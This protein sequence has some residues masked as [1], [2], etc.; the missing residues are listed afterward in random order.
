MRVVG[1]EKW[2]KDKATF[3]SPLLLWSNQRVWPIKPFRT[4]L[5]AEAAH[6]PDLP[7]L[8]RNVLCKNGKKAY[9]ILIPTLPLM[10]PHKIPST[11]CGS[12]KRLYCVPPYPRTYR[13]PLPAGT[14]Q[15]EKQNQHPS[16][17][18]TRNG[19]DLEMAIYGHAP[20]NI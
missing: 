17:H 18:S 14:P 8:R 15:S 7:S 19:N 11:C 3:G 4:K 9:C 20:A 2:G 5:P 6:L 16:L 1:R 13:S 12:L 10:Q